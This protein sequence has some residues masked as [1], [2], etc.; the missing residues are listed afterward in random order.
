MD[1]QTFNLT[2]MLIEQHIEYLIMLG[3]MGMLWWVSATVLSFKIIVNMYQNKEKYFVDK[4]RIPIGIF[5]SSFFM[6]IIIFGINESYYILKL[7]NETRRLLQ[8]INSFKEYEI[9][10]MFFST[11]INFL[12]GSTS[13][14]FFLIIW[15]VLWFKKDSANYDELDNDIL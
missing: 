2:Q 4:I 10:V 11:L 14:V 3:Q 12:I 15:L 7:E 8:S 6:S 13:F 5:I 9:S 1:Q